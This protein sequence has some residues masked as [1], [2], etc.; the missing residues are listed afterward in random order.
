MFA[1]RSKVEEESPASTSLWKEVGR[2]TY[3]VRFVSQERG[4]VEARVFNRGKSQDGMGP[5]LVR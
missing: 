1:E 4:G 5:G 2:R 3:A